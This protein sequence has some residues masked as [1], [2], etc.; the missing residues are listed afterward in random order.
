MEG[1][2]DSCPGAVTG[3]FEDFEKGEG[4][5]YGKGE[6][7]K[8]SQTFKDQPIKKEVINGLKALGI[9]KEFD[10]DHTMG[11]AFGNYTISEGTR[12]SAA[13][14]FLSELGE[15]K[16]LYSVL[17]AHVSQIIFDDRSKVVGV[18][19]LLNNKLIRVQST[20]EVILSAGSINTPH[21]LMNSEVGPRKHL[22]SFGIR[23]VKELNVGENLQ[24][25]LVFPNLFY[26]VNNEA[27]R[28][29]SPKATIDASYDYFM[30]RKGPIAS[31]SQFKGFF[32]HKNESTKPSLQLYPTRNSKGYLSVPFVVEAH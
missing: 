7:L 9:Y 11:F 25:H 1:V 24:D 32:N 10:H 8:I 30:H 21:I 29:T 31:S 15:R 2:V 26:N 28:E 6:D 22:E 27:V 18:E 4:E 17:K 3:K 19:T 16:N 13:K 23:V 12:Y 5:I 14:D 20:K